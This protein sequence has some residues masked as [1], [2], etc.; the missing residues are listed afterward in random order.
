MSPVHGSQHRAAMKGGEN[1]PRS[2]RGLR[3][4]TPAPAS[5]QYKNSKTGTEVTSVRSEPLPPSPKKGAEY[6]LVDRTKHK[7]K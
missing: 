7:E 1:V 4:G 3:P 5:G 2:S 6:T